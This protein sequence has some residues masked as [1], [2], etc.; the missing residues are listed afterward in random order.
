MKPLR[1]LLL[2]LVLLGLSTL[3][4]AYAASSAPDSVQFGPTLDDFTDISNTPD[5]LQADAL[6]ASGGS[7]SP[8]GTGTC[9]SQQVAFLRFNLASLTDATLTG[10]TL[11]LRSLGSLNGST[12]LTMK[13][14]GSYDDGWQEGVAQI[15]WSGPRLD[16]DLRSIATGPVAAGANIVFAND[17][18][19]QLVK[20]LQSQIKNTN[21]NPNADQV[22]TIGIQTIACGGTFPSRQ[23]M[24]SMQT[25]GENAVPAILT[26]TGQKPTAIQVSAASAERIASPI[27][28]GIGAVV[29]FV[30]AG[31]VVSRRRAG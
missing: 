21:S 2:I 25:T 5:L 1:T 9:I 31:I 4:A 17:A 22:A 14:W 12:S 13:L 8:G 19:G 30:V 15:A 16:L 28:A 10:A 6:L 26:L 3:P 7:P 27:Y 11:T 20:F 24:A 23:Y 18:T 29:L